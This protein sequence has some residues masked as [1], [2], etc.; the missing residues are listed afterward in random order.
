MVFRKAE[1]LRMDKT[2]WFYHCL[3]DRRAAASS[4]SSDIYREKVSDSTFGRIV[5]AFSHQGNCFLHL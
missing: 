5:V 1:Y 3:V 2:S 4:L